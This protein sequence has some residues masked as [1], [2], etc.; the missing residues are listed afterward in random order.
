VGAMGQT[1]PE[2]MA[3]AIKQRGTWAIDTMRITF[4]GEKRGLNLRQ[5]LQFAEL[6]FFYLLSV[7]VLVFAV[8]PLFSLTLG[9]Y[10]LVT[11]YASYAVYFWPLAVAIELLL[12][13]LAEGLPYEDLWRARQTWLGMAPVYAKATLIA[14]R[15]GP[16]RKPVY[17][18][19]R[20]EHVYRWYWQET[21][22]QLL[23]VVALA[24]ASLYHVLTESLLTTADLG[25]LF[26]AAFFILGLSRTVA[27][28]W[29]GV[30]LR[31]L[32]RALPRRA[33]EKE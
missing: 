7:A 4:F 17:R 33:A 22:P 16:H 8:T 26:W 11:T 25:S 30:D 27:N 5:H 31:Q 10:P 23:L 9:I 12:V 2:D 21:M 18:V 13:S 20:K 6:G 32:V 24:G 15:F 19:T 28:S 29:H 1:A 3:N 14:L